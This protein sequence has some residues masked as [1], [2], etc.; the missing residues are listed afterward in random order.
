MLFPNVDQD[1]VLWALEKS[2]SYT[3]KSMYIFFSCH[4]V[5]NIRLQKLWKSKLPL[6]LKVFM[7]LA[8][9]GRLQTGVALK[10]KNWKGDHRCGLCVVAEDVE[11]IFFKCITACFVWPCLNEALGWRGVPA[12]LQISFDNWV[13]LG[14]LN[15]GLNFSLCGGVLGALC[16]CVRVY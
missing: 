1:K 4:G 10:E 9:Q 8:K 13:H 14:G 11:H 3:S 7:R 5:V 2:N 6:K 12:D 15:V 16:N